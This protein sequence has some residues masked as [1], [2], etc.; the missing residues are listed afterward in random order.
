MFWK[1]RSDLSDAGIHELSGCGVGRDVQETGLQGRCRQ[2]QR[3]RRNWMPSWARSATSPNR[4][5]L[6]PA[7]TSFQSF[8]PARAPQQAPSSHWARACRVQWP[9]MRLTASPAHQG[10]FFG[11]ARYAFV[12]QT[13]SERVPGKTRALSRCELKRKTHAVPDYSDGANVIS[14]PGGCRGHSVRMS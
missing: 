8:P 9:R 5:W 13:R 2:N 10:R 14:S 7:L 4:R 12:W 3:L 6:F 1:R 11:D